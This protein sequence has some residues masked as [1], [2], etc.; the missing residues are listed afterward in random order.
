M[1]IK[2]PPVGESVYEALIARWLKKD[3]E[4]VHRDEAL[5]EIETD[6]VTVEVAAEADGILNII[7]PEVETVKIGAVIGTIEEEGAEAAAK[8]EKAAPSATAPAAAPHAEGARQPEAMPPAAAAQ[9]A[10]QREPAPAAPVAPAP[11]APAEAA[12]KGPAEAASQP[13]PMSPSG[14]KLAREMGVETTELKGTGRGGRV[15]VEDLLKGQQEKPAAAE[16]AAATPPP[17]PPPAGLE[18]APEGYGQVPRGSARGVARE[19]EG[20]G[21]AQA[22]AA[23]E[24]PY[25]AAPGAPPGAPAGERVTRKPMPPI[26]KRIAERLVSVRQ[27]TAMLT[28]FNE[29]DMSQ[30]LQLRKKHGE[31]FLKRHQVKLGLM[32]LF[33]R[34]CSLAL[35]E[36]PDVNASIEGDDIVYH[37]YCDI[38]IAVGG[39]KGLVVPVLRGAEALTLAEIEQRI[40]AFGEKIRTNRLAIADLEGGTFT[41]SNG[42]IYGSLLSTPIL[43]PPQSGVLGM[44]S[45]QDRAVVRDGQVVVRPMM[46]L[47]L[48]Y[49]HRIV[50]GK[51]AVGFLKMVKE[52]IEEP[53]QMLLEG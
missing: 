42:G 8:P 53:D 40:A 6:K 20:G 13:P 30:V 3:G 47:A 18:R 10:P 27:Q 35:R 45:I 50:D 11:Q 52:C 43:N 22:V 48:S 21:T 33:V 32:S 19:A 34:A 28:T 39:E 23:A 5:C 36:F 51:G 38:G 25:A 41:L 1:E 14:R 9:P 2:V 17:V 46:Y 16:A 24:A 44:H 15:T 12:P 4:K 7:V 26:R 49:D 31:Q 29:A 37:N